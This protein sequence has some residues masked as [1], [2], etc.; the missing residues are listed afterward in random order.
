MSQPS[1]LLGPSF[2]SAPPLPPYSGVAEIEE[3]P[4]GLNSAFAVL[5]RAFIVE[6]PDLISR[7]VYYICEQTRFGDDNLDIGIDTLVKNGVFSAQYPLHDGHV[8][9]HKGEAPENERQA[10]QTDWAAFGRI[11]KYQP[12]HGIKEYLGEKVA[13]YFAWLGFY[14][15]CLL[16]AAIVGFICFLYG[17][18]S[19]FSYIPVKEICSPKNSSLYYM[20][21][22]CDKLCSYYLLSSTTCLYA[23]VTHWFDNQA[24]LFFALFMSLWAVFFLEFWKRKQV[25]LAYE[26]H[27][28]DFEEEEERPRP[29]YLARVTTLKENLVTGKMEPSMPAKQRVPRLMGALGIVLFFIV[30]V[31]AGVTSVIVYR[32]A[33]YAILLSTDSQ[34]IRTRAKLV[35]AG[36]RSVLLLCF[37]YQG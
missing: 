17:V 29:E 35:V 7:L 20:C 15:A 30:L 8:Q 12:I 3:V 19:S 2:F 23:K 26:W 32:A 1:S 33:I 28:M 13:L 22:L 4:R 31:V 16:P 6:N 14:T 5:N 24:T 34:Q 36:K 9:P 25:S 21:P 37:S 10:L 11:F 18:G 27:T